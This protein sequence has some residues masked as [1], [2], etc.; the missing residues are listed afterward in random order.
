M[1]DAEHA[2]WRLA[3]SALLDEDREPPSVALD[4]EGYATTGRPP[5]APETPKDP[6]TEQPEDPWANVEVKQPA[7]AGQD[8]PLPTG[9]AGPN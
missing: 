4:D 7:D 5:V 1:R 9:G 8:T 3:F 6:A 2:P